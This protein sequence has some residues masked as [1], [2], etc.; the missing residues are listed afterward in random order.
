MN[1]TINAQKG[2]CK[3]LASVFM[4]VAYTGTLFLLS[5]ILVQSSVSSAAAATGSSKQRQAATGIPRRERNLDHLDVETLAYY[6]GLD[7][8]TMKPI[9]V[10]PNDNDNDDGVS[11]SYVGYDVAV[12][13]YAQRSEE[14]HTLAP[15]WDNIALRLNAGSKSSN[16]V[17]GLFNCELD[18]QSFELCEA[19]GVAVY[20]TLLYVGA[21]VFHDRNPVTSLLVGEKTAAG[22]MGPTTIDRAVKFR[23]D[24]RYTE[25]V[26]D[27]IMTMRF[28]SSGHKR[29][30]LQRLRNLIFFPLAGKKNKGKKLP[31]GVPKRMGGSGISATKYSTLEAKLNKTTAELEASVKSM[32]HTTEMMEAMFFPHKNDTDVFT[33]MKESGTWDTKTAVTVMDKTVRSCVMEL[34]LDYCKRF[35]VDIATKYVE[36]FAEGQEFPSMTEV[37]ALLQKQINDTEPFCAIID[38]CVSKEFNEDQC[39]PTEC[40]FKNIVACNYLTSCQDEY[41]QKEYA[42]ALELIAEGDTFPP[43]VSKTTTTTTTDTTGK[44][45]SSGSGRST[46]WGF[47]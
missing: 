42:I 11:S 46:A 16:L 12:M 24:W 3:S 22:A 36:S 18:M 31:V 40:P 25:S 8:V 6:T 45:Q 44:T 26:M 34:S 29:K 23:G 5:S 10:D 17:M 47:G 13:F 27:W 30:W 38:H 14:C 33:E 4:A 35:S 41:I 1:M 20:P 32:S 19:L 21:V 9:D 39:Q 28:L 43:A 15:Y 7:P 2:R 37:E